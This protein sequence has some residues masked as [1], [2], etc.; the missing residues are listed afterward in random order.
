MSDNNLAYFI[1]GVAAVIV[2]IKVLEKDSPKPL[3]SEI[4]TDAPT[5][6]IEPDRISRALDKLKNGGVK[7]NSTPEE[8][9]N[10]I[11]K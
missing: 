9:I 5:T 1:V 4:K 7:V 2:L 6:N 11:G 10:A 3:M 8:T